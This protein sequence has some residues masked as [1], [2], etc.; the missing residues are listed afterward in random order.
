[1]LLASRSSGCSSP[2]EK[3]TRATVGELHARCM[4]REEYRVREV[5]GGRLFSLVLGASPAPAPCQPHLRHREAGA[6]IAIVGSKACTRST[7]GVR[8][9]RFRAAI[10]PYDVVPMTYVGL[11]RET[12]VANR[13]VANAYVCSFKYSSG[14]NV[15]TGT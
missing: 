11:Y 14:V 5:V 4:R 2:I 6:K 1:M 15:P 7:C 12:I 13:S 10:T 3:R 8:M 9:E